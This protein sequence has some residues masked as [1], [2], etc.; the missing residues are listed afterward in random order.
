MSR[1]AFDTHFPDDRSC[2]RH[3]AELRWPDGFQCLMCEGE[4]L[5]AEAKT[6]H[7]ELRTLL[8]AGVGYRRNSHAPLKGELAQVVRAHPPD[9]PPLEWHLEQAGTSPI[10]AWKLL[11]GLLWRR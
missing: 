10:R 1:S 3:L 6:L 7:V 9:D 11:H 8:P 2:A 4:W 5:R